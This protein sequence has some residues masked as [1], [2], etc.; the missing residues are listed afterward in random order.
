MNKLYILG[1]L[2]LS[3][4]TAYVSIPVTTILAIISPVVDPNKGSYA[5]T[6]TGDCYSTATAVTLDPLSNIYY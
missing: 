4:V 5:Y 2:A 3:N 1:A 6:P